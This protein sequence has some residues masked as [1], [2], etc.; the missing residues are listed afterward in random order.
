MKLFPF[1]PFK[2]VLQMVR[3][4]KDMKAFLYQIYE[5]KKKEF[6]EEKKNGT[7]RLKKD[8]IHILLETQDENVPIEDRLTDDEISSQYANFFGAG[9]G[10]TSHLIQLV[11][12]HIIQYP[13]YKDKI[14][15][16]T[17]AYIK[18]IDN[19]THW[20]LAKMEYL[21]GIIKE[22][23]R[24]FGPIQQCFPRE[25]LEAHQLNG[26]NIYKGTVVSAYLGI[27]A[28][29]EKYFHEPQ[30]FNPERWV[31]NNAEGNSLPNPFA[32][33][34]FFAG[35]KH[36][37]GQVLAQLEVKIFII[38][39]LAKYEPKMKP[40]YELRMTSRFAYEPIDPIMITLEKRK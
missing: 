40:E 20:E 3:E 14:R 27:N 13:E 23:L 32:Y 16:E 4:L 6:L 12:Y 11:L 25:A 34:P 9:S 1:G 17:Q 30:K 15:Q 36:C 5:G 19:I 18:D 37:I 8:L 35:P 2:K 22:T 31:G 38:Q 24:L 7:Q 10:T 39:I 28:Q 26:L 21:N 29:K 33:I